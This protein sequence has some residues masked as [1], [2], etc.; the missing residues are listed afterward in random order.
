MLGLMA[1][2]VSS[3]SLVLTVLSE[4]QSGHNTDLYYYIITNL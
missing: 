2:L 4:I 3:S 1:R